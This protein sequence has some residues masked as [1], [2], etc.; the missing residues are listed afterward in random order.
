LILRT[1]FKVKIHAWRRVEETSLISACCV[2]DIKVAASLLDRGASLE[3]RRVENDWT[4]LMHAVVLLL[5]LHGADV[6]ARSKT[7]GTALSI[8]R[9]NNRTKV[10][11]L[12]EAWIAATPTD[13]A[14]GVS[15]QIKAAKTFEAVLKEHDSQLIKEAKRLQAIHN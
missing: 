5:L 13:L 3:V 6:E 2:G 7:G 12:L 14:P 8:A 9:V 4:A 10:V 1:R 11:S 15:P